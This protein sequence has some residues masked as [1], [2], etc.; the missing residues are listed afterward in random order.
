MRG[1]GFAGA[2]IARRGMPGDGKALSHF[3]DHEK[4]DADQ[5]KAPRN[6][7]RNDETSSAADA[8]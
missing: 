3:D 5:C 8:P 2:G 1:K 7:P 4:H 6:A